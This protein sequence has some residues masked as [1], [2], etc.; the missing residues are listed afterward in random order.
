M[1]KEK[2]YFRKA[3][4]KKTILFFSLA[5]SY[6]LSSGFVSNAE[7]QEPDVPNPDPYV[8]E[9]TEYEAAEDFVNVPV[10]DE[11]AEDDIEVI[12][13]EDD[14]N[15]VDEADSNSVDEADLNTV[16]KNENNLNA[17][18]SKLQV[19][20][21]LTAKD[22]A[23]ATVEKPVEE[24]V[25]GVHDTED[26]KKALFNGDEV[27]TEFTGL[28]YDKAS[29]IWYNLVEGYVTAG[30]DMVANEY[31]GWY[32]DKYGKIDFSFTGILNTKDGGFFLEC[33]KYRKN[34]TGLYYNKADRVWYNLVDS[35]VT[36]GPALVQNENGWWYI[37]EKGTIDYSA[38]TVAENKYGHWK[39]K[40]GKVDFS[41]NGVAY[42]YN[43]V[44][45]YFKNGR[46]DKTYRGLYYNSL[47]RVWY[48]INIGNVEAG[49][50]FVKNEY[51][52][53]Y[54][55]KEGRVD[56]NYKGIAKYGNEILYTGGGKVTYDKTLLYYNAE[57]RSW[58]NIVNSK[59]K[60]GPALAQNE[61][62]L[63]Y[64]N[65][66]GKIDFDYWGLARNQYGNWFVESGKVRVN[67]N[68]LLRDPA[69]GR[70]YNFSGGK[71]LEKV[72]VAQNKYG[73]WFINNKGT[74]DFG[75]RTG[76]FRQG[77]LWFRFD[78]SQKP[79]EI[80]EKA[81][82]VTQL[83]GYYVSPM[84]T[85]NLNSKED[86]IEAMISRAYEYVGTEYVI[87]K[88][89]A[90]KTGADCSGLVMQCLYAAGYDPYPAT[91]AHHALPENEY[92]SRTFYSS[93]PIR[94]IS[95]SELK[96]GDVVWY[97]SIYSGKINHIAIYLGGD[98]IIDAI[99]PYTDVHNMYDDYYGPFYGFG[100]VFE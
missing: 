64:I 47:N 65:K 50:K 22:P 57:D 9:T 87:C 58:Y 75:T 35:K 21:T 24:V 49:P 98:K 8:T 44:G 15:S 45:W 25:E 54:V 46:I 97:K 84:K 1:R 76:W 81:P 95:K 12:V 92:D 77:N 18:D 30:P 71:V 20:D 16:D 82:S 40:K 32:V 52:I 26:G 7:G 19:E 17:A 60:A 55:N 83:K 41:F 3:K 94:H 56:F 99:E 37:S 68:G 59:I 78:K 80:T 5:T 36:P 70:W 62:G 42:D 69:T 73:W 86:R 31:G 61:N 10:I 6:V 79:V 34:K 27:N 90:P 39:V 4:I 66:E 33:G 85:G 93:V 48:N 28:Y 89:G 38:D 100:R 96:R 29:K 51:G 2:W 53:W 72:A 23:L 13:D 63:W 11:A 74:V 67:K 91:P 88:S 43:K 14:S